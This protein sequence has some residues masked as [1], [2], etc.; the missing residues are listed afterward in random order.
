MKKFSDVYDGVFLCCSL[1]PP[2]VLDEILNFTETVI[3]TL[4]T[5]GPD[6][7]ESKEQ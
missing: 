3:S 4:P 2:D 5:L 7:L 6:T 1:S